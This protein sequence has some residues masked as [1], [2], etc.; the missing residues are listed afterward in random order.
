MKASNECNI[1]KQKQ[2]RDSLLKSNH[3]L[4]FIYGHSPTKPLIGGHLGHRLE[5]MS[6]DA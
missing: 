4:T 1:F 3:L 6:H 2:G 5:Q